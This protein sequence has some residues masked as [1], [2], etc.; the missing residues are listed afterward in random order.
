MFMCGGQW[1]RHCDYQFGN[2]AF[3]T[4]S[5]GVIT[6]WNQIAV[7]RKIAEFLRQNSIRTE[8]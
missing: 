7:S 8:G 1:H 2:C 6:D 5:A 4:P 3:V